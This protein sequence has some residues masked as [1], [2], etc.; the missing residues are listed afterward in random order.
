MFDPNSP[1]LTRPVEALDHDGPDMPAFVKRHR[2]FFALLVIVTAQ[3][4]LL[5]LQIIRNNHVRL[6]RYWAVEAFDPF[7]RSLGGLMNV[8]STAYRTYRHLWRADQENQE[9]HIQLVAAQAQIQRLGEQAGETQRLRNLLDFKNQLAFQTVA[10][11][12]IASSL[13]NTSSPGEN[14][15]A[16]FIDKG[17]DS[18]LTADLAV[19]TPEGVVGKIL[20][21]FPHSAQVL[22]I[23]DASSGVGV[24]LAQ[25]RVQGILKGGSSSLCDLHY[26]MNEEVVTRGEAVVTSGL[27][28]VYPKGLPVGIVVTV[29]DGNIYKTINVK[30]S[31]DLN[32]LEVVLVVLRTAAAE[33]QA[34]NNP[35]SR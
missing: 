11:E 10:A 4:L 18:G 17:S 26:V 34:L 31:A 21:I 1:D 27:D 22:L 7:E 16:I 19:I 32:R 2:S 5:S 20:A 9:L 3:I 25:S 12:V 14:S 29:G 13:G 6:I 8:S 33:Q 28:Q 15:N 23:T 35:A 24:T 30:P